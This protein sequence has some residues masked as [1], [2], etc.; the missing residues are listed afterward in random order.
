MDMEAITRVAHMQLKRALIFTICLSDVFD[1]M[2]T[3]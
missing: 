1:A 2:A 3:S